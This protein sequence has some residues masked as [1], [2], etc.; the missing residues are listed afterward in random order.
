MSGSRDGAIARAE[1]YFDEGGFLADLQRRVAI[2]T[3]SQESDS[4]PALQEYVSGEMTRS[5]EKL[6][7]DCTVL[8]NPRAEYGPFLIARRVEEEGK[9]TV[10][11]YGHGDVIRGQ[12]E[13]WRSGLSPWRI[14]TEGDR[15]YGRG[16]AD[17]KGQHTINIAALACVLEE[18]GSLGF[19][20]TI[21]IETG[22]ET[23]SPGLA[24]F[25]KANKAALQADALIGSD[26]PR[27]DHRRPTIFGGTRG[28]MNFDLRLTLREGGHHSGNWGGLLSNPGIVLA[29]ALATITDRRGQIKVPEWRPT[30]LTNSVRAALADA[31]VDAGEGAPAIDPDW[32]EESLTPVERVFGWNSFE[33][34]AF[35][36]GNPDRPVNAIPP[37]AVAHCQLRFVVG[38]D[39]EDIV[40]AL[41]RHLERHGFGAIEVTPSREVIMNATRLDPDNPW[42]RFAADS[43]TKTAG[44]KPNMLPNLG[45]S[46]PNEVFT[47]ILGMP[48]VWVPHSYAAC[49]QHAPNEHLLAPV[50]RDGLRLM[51]G[52]FWDLGAQGRPG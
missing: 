28:T 13:Q 8:P 16:T 46:L 39:P 6:G 51:T 31:H 18:R 35:K 4:M 22:E 1:K 41:R 26:G 7:Y 43:I 25:C 11:T 30:T 15:L 14:V 42:A 36:T 23:G 48:T 45:G 3:T 40:P 34:L 29:H 52:L 5:L 49:S 9:P 50:A 38:T 32:G 37:S 21:L 17:N 19:N 47:E 33:V 10:L 27:L 12:E 20:S 44:Q 2:P 24:E